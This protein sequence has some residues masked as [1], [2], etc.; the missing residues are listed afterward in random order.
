MEPACI[1]FNTS[2]C[3]SRKC[4][5]PPPPPPPLLHGG[6]FCFRPPPPWH[7]LERIFPSKMLLNFTIMR[8]ISLLQHLRQS[9]GYA[10]AESNKHIEQWNPPTIYRIFWR[11]EIWHFDT[12][13]GFSGSGRKDAKRLPP[14]LFPPFFAL[15]PFHS[16]LAFFARPHWPRAWHRLISLSSQSAHYVSYSGTIMV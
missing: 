12:T 9:F 15:S 1:V 3:S 4:Q 7:T 13:N 11:F 16:S 10:R 5:I 2:L 14:S 6:H 8:K